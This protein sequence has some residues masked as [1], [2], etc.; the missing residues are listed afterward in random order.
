MNKIIGKGTL[1]NAPA[2]IDTAAVPA[3][4]IRLVKAITLCN[5]TAVDCWVTVTFDGT[6]ILYRYVVPGQ[7]DRE[8]NTITIP[9]VDQVMTAGMRISGHAQVSTSIDYYISGVEMDVS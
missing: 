6:N 7:G 4:H 1:T 9:F 8:E 2:N 5:K 3:S